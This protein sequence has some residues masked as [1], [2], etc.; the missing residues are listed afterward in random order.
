[1]SQ[2]CAASVEVQAVFGVPAEE[3]LNVAAGADM[4]VVGSRGA[5]GF[6]KLLLGSVAGPAHPVRQWA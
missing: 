5:G 6:E 1:M 4:V 2:Q 3:L